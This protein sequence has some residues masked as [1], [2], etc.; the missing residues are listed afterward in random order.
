MSLR[1]DLVDWTDWDGAAYALARSL[2]L[3]DASVSFATDA[4]HIFWSDNPVG[5]S[6]HSAL[7]AFVVAGFLERRDEPDIQFRWRSDFR[8][9]WGTR[10][11]RSG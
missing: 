3:M 5:R 8:G 2:G 1:E 11:A 6:L 4:K 9:S 10:P 7:E